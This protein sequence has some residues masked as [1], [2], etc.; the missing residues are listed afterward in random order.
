MAKVILT[1][2]NR[3]VREKGWRALVKELGLSGATR[4]LLQY[5]EGQGNYTEERRNIF[6][7]KNVADIAKEI[8]RNRK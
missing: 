3:Q 2:T 8:M 4:F 5:E 6:A 7:E 1:L